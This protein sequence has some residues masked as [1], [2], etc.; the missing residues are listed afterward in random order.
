VWRQQPWRKILCQSLKTEL[1]N[2]LPEKVRT[3]RT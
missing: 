2:N 1:L 3:T